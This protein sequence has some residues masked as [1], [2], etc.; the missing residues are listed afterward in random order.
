[1]RADT[2]DNLDKLE[3]IYTFT[4][5]GETRKRRTWALFVDKW[6]YV[7]ILQ[8]TT[9]EE[10]AS[11]TPTG[12]YA[13]AR[14]ELPQELWFATDRDLSPYARATSDDGTED[15]A[16]DAAGDAPEAPSTPGS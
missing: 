8:G 12:N 5:G 6:R 2:L 14:F 4:E 15:A 10:F 13:F 1:A 3:R 16:A 9:P 7:L 11:R